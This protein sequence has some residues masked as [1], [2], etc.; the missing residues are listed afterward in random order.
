MQ[1]WLQRECRE[2]IT[3]DENAMSGP[4]YASQERERGREERGRTRERFL[5][6]TY[7]IISSSVGKSPYDTKFCSFSTFSQSPHCFHFIAKRGFLELEGFEKL[8]TEELFYTPPPVPQIFP[9]IWG[10][11]RQGSFVFVPVFRNILF[12]LTIKEIIYQQYHMSEC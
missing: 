6:Q 11:G 10:K 3:E 4:V 12:L 9:R 2:H 5:I 1:R 8:L 7:R